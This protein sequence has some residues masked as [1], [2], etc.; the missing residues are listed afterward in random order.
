VADTTTDEVLLQSDICE[1]LW[2]LSQMDPQQFINEVK[3][4]FVLAYPGWSVVK[5][6]YAERKIYLRDDRNN[7]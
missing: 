3:E 2:E 5:A 7:T 4:Y 6:K 1:R